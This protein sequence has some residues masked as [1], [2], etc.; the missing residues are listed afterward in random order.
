[1]SGR[2]NASCYAA[3]DGKPDSWTLRPDGCPGTYANVEWLITQ[4]HSEL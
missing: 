4:S 3:G 1:M 2:K